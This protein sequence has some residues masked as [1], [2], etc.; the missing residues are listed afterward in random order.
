[1]ME[2]NGPSRWHF[3]VSEKFLTCTDDG[4]ILLPYLQCKGGICIHKTA[5]LLSSKCTV[6]FWTNTLQT[7]ENKINE[8][9]VSACIAVKYNYNSIYIQLKT[10]ALKHWNCTQLICSVTC[11]YNNGRICSFFILLVFRCML[12]F[13]FSTPKRKL[14]WWSLAMIC[15]LSVLIAIL[16]CWQSSTM[17]NELIITKQSNSIRTWSMSQ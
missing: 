2:L 11:W 13:G 7:S 8:Y 5:L 9:K 17:F 15:K 1:M 10:C 14:E 12:G 6:T 3:S 4:I 16:R